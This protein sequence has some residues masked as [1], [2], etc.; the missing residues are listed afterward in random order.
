MDDQLPVEIMVC[1]SGPLLLRGS[2]TLV[3]DTRQSVRRV[4]G[5]VALCRCGT[6]GRPPFCDGSHKLLRRDR[7]EE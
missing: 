1:R 3:S 2:F 4:D 6:T 5:P 7:V